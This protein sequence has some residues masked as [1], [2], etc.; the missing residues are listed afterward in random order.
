MFAQ[1]LE[2]TSPL[3]AYPATLYNAVLVFYA[4]NK[5]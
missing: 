3:F 4:I 2:L 1:E 5:C